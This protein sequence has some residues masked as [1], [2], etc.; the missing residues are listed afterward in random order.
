MKGIKTSE[1]KYKKVSEMKHGNLR[2]NSE[3]KCARWMSPSGDYV[4]LVFPLFALAS[5]FG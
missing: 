3:M 2:K 1:M 4:I 5:T